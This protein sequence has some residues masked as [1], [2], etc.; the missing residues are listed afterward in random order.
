MP[1]IT[2][3]QYTDACS[4]ALLALVLLQSSARGS[5]FQKLLAARLPRLT[6]CEFEQSFAEVEIIIYG[7]FE[8]KVN[9]RKFR[10]YVTDV[11][12][13]AQQQHLDKELL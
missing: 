6:N 3:F 8:K 5:C 13:N 12:I 2:T 11:Q 4:T 1:V 9:L 7:S 10:K